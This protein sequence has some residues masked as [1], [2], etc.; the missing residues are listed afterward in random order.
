MTSRTKYVVCI[1]D[2]CADDPIPGL[3]GRTPLEVAPMP[4]LARLAAHGTIGRARTIPDGFPKCSSVGNMAIF[5]YDPLVFYTGRAPLEAAALGVDLSGDQVA[6]RVNLVTVSPDGTMLDFTGG[7]PAQA[8]AANVIDELNARSGGEVVFHAGQTYRHIMTCPPDWAD[9]VCVP[10]HDLLGR[11][12]VGPAG[13]SA[14]KLSEVMR[15]SRAVLDAAPVDATQIWLW[16]QGR[17]PRLPDF[18]TRHGVSGALVAAVNVVR[19]LGTLTGMR[20][21]DVPGATGWY[22]T[23]YAAKREAA[24]AA[25]ADG[26]DLA[27]VHVAATD[28]AGH[29]GDAEAKVASL[30]A[31]DR[32][33]LRGL[34]EGLDRL[35]PWRL[36]FLPDHATPVSLRTH[37]DAPVPFLMCGSRGE[38]TGGRYCEA[39]AA[40]RPAEPAH[41]LIGRLVGAG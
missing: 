13:P 21:I 28:E 20:V 5:G 12:A 36:L 19:G 35:G 26:C 3:G 16:S 4:T 14:D 9:A 2:G 18:A 11:P 29:A 23:D 27:I 32:L 24:L 25:L 39:A 6:F 31:W 1:A 10:P 40:G 38:F 37:T 17:P 33:V 30:A 41:E 15:A 8:E 22:D 34:V 7:R